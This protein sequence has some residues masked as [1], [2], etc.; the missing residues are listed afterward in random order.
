MASS[1]APVQDDPLAADVPTLPTEEVPRRFAEALARATDDKQH[2]VLTR[3]GEPVAALIPIEA[4]GLLDRVFE[5]LEDEVDLREVYRLREEDEET[6][7]WE[8]V[9]RKLD[10]A[11]EGDEPLSD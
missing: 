6:I 2:V 5:A 7:P 3:E 11:E 10:L 1:P 8:E 9:E 4:L